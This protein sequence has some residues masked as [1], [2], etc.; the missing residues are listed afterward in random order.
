MKNRRLLILML[1][2][3]AVQIKVPAWAAA[4]PEA[5]G[6]SESEEGS[7]SLT[8]ANKSSRTR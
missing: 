6:T 3:I 1:Y 2:L 8:D 4:D 5:M 7:E